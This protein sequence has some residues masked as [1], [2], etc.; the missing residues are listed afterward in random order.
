VFHTYAMDSLQLAYYPRRYNAV[1]IGTGELMPT[2]PMLQFA[3]EKRMNKISVQAG[4]GFCIP[5]SYVVDGIHGKADGY[6]LRIEGRW[7]AFQDKRRPALAAYVGCEAYYKQ[8][9]RPMAGDFVRADTLVNP[10]DRYYADNYVLHKSMYCAVGKAGFELRFRQHFLFDVSLGLGVKKVNITHTER[11]YPGDEQFRRLNE[12]PF[13]ID[14]QP[15]TD[16]G[17]K[18]DPAL[19]FNISLGYFFK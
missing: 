9:K 18:L 16:I 17:E 2:N 11:K 14:S 7:Y 6:T 10:N 1:K 4:F 8:Y 3:F 12:N 19:P 13:I 5:K 15:D